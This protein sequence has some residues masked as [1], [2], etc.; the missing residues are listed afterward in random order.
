MP[1]EIAIRAIAFAAENEG[2]DVATFKRVGVI[3]MDGKSGDK[4]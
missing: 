3:P 2:N 4:S 1:A